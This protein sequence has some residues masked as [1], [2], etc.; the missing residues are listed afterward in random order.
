ML[1]RDMRIRLKLQLGK[2]RTGPWLLFRPRK[3]ICKSLIP[4]R[5]PAFAE[6]RRGRPGLRDDAPLAVRPTGCSTRSSFWKR[7]TSNVQLRTS[8]DFR[9]CSSMFDVRRSMFDVRCSMFDVRC[10]MFDVRC[11]MFDV[12]GRRTSR[13]DDTSNHTSPCVARSSQTISFS[14]SP[15]ATVK[16]C[17]KTV[18]S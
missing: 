5:W 10:S 1:N 15:G 16:S 14:S 18:Q 11:S 6:L 7:R 9:F 12:Y 2:A 3:R 4:G 8:N 17:C 13:R